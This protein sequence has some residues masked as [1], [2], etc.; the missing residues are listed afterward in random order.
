MTEQH[1]GLTNPSGSS[2]GPAGRQGPGAT[3][4]A[5]PN[6]AQPARPRSPNRQPRS[7]HGAS[8]QGPGADRPAVPGNHR[9]PR[10]PAAGEGERAGTPATQP[11]NREDSQRPRRRARTGRRGGSAPPCACA[12]CSLR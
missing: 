6:G 11:R 5:S 7:G 4:C 1:S 8:P 12:G 9:T 10:S 3:P 2:A